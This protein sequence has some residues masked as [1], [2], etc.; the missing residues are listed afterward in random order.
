MQNLLKNILSIFKR[1]PT[2]LRNK[3]RV[4][5]LLLT[6]SV[7]LEGLTVSAVFPFLLVYTDP[8]SLN[9]H[10]IIQSLLPSYL[11]L[12]E[13]RLFLFILFIS[14]ICGATAIKIFSI[15]RNISL[16]QLIGNYLAAEI[17]KK[18]VKK[19]YV[20]QESISS[21]FLLGIIISKTNEVVEKSIIPFLVLLSSSL[22]MLA[23]L[24]VISIF[25]GTK[26]I[27]VGITIAMIYLLLVRILKVKLKEKSNNISSSVTKLTQQV[28]N[29]KYQNIQVKLTNSEKTVVADFKNVD[30]LYRNS[31]AFVQIASAAPK[32]ILELLGVI[33]IC[34]VFVLSSDSDNF[35]TLIPSIGV[36]LF[37]AQRS[38]PLLQAIYANFTHISGSAQSTKEILE[39]LKTEDENSSSAQFKKQLLEHP[40]EFK[41]L[42][43]IIN[44]AGYQGTML[45][46]DLK[47]AINRGDKILITGRSGSGK[48]TLLSYILQLKKIEDGKI[49]LNNEWDIQ[50]INLKNYYDYFSYVEQIPYFQDLTLDELIVGFEKRYDQKYLDLVKDTVD[51]PV[52]LP[53]NIVQNLA[54]IGEDGAKLSGG[55][56]QRIAIARALYRQKSILL[57][58]EATSALDRKSEAKI[59]KN[60]VNNH[61]K[62]TTI[63][64]THGNKK[65]MDWTK[66][67]DVS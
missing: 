2:T 40:Q 50:T 7:V 63:V 59:F 61:P 27:F 23:I 46:T 8:S 39:L 17:V 55:Q 15:V 42:D 21:S 18:F 11:N 56:R 47:L 41:S 60:I 38:L 62:L 33:M 24:A 29:A 25:H 20:E 1:I 51:I 43:I 44:Y 66:I 10:Q 52:S 37:A 22:S 64:V 14:L 9:E 4:V 3:T 19:N 48:S 16:G 5:V 45:F 32:Y 49:I 13:K 34:S 54:T 6:L 12:N 31:R 53:T 30:W 57:M 28:Y 26:I 67:L 35:A 65:L 36:L 58:D